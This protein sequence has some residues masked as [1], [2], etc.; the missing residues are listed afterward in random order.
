MTDP[1]ASRQPSDFD[2]ISWLPIGPPYVWNCVPKGVKR[3]SGSCRRT[4]A[5]VL[6]PKPSLQ[7]GAGNQSV[8]TGDTIRARVKCPTCSSR[9]SRSDRQT[10]VRTSRIPYPWKTCVPCLYRMNDN[11]IRMLLVR[12]SVVT[13]ESL[14]RHFCISLAFE[15]MGI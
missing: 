10:Q 2:T 12:G 9:D 8:L 6:L 3:Y 7:A 4:S 1:R 11:A 13:E 15:R 5:R 14:Y